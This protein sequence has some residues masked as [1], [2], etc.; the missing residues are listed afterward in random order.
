MSKIKVFDR[1]K[2][3]NIEIDISHISKIA[4]HVG[5][6]GTPIGGSL[7]HTKE[8]WKDPDTGFSRNFHEVSQSIT[9]IKKLIKLANKVVRGDRL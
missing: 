4:E 6:N 8:P 3:K 1:I 2:E 5:M 9:M 7:I